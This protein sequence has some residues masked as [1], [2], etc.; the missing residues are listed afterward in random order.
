MAYI[1][2]ETKKNILNKIKTI[3]KEHDSKIKVTASIRN[4]SKLIIN[5]KSKELEEQHNKYNDQRKSDSL[6][7]KMRDMQVLFF[8]NSLNVST[9]EFYNKI[10]K[11]IQEVGGYYNN[12]DVMTD[13]FDCAFYYDCEIS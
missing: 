11:A 7:W 6:D 4:Y 13:Y 12:T 2:Q 10:E 3:I 1:A 8:P 9:I 5:L